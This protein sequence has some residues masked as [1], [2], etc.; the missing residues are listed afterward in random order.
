MLLLRVS[1]V[2]LQIAFCVVPLQI[3]HVLLTVKPQP[4]LWLM[5]ELQRFPLTA[6]V[7]RNWPPVSAA[8]QEDGTGLPLPQL[9]V[10]R[11]EKLSLT[12]KAGAGFQ[13]RGFPSNLR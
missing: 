13:L 10:D 2:D 5:P 6:I 7:S 11:L 3:D 8:A 9:F 12:E 4:L 1:R